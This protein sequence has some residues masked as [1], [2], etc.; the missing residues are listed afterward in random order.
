MVPCAL[1]V[2]RMAQPAL[3]ERYGRGGFKC[4]PPPFRR[5]DEGNAL[6]RNG[7]FLDGFL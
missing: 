5:P 1:Q 2:S 6:Q 7:L 3:S 4:G